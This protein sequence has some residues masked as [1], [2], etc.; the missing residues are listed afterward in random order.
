MKAM[1]Y[2]NRRWLGVT[3]MAAALLVL[4]P[5]AEAAID[6][7]TGT[8]FEFTAKEGYITTPD[9]GSIYC[10]GYSA[11]GT[12]SAH[13]DGRMQYPGPTLIL[14]EGQTY[15][16]TLSN[17]LP[18]PVSLIFPGLTVT[19]ASGDVDGDIT[20]E[21]NAY[22]AGTEIAGTA[23]YT[24][25]ADAPGT[26]LYHSG[27]NP[28]VQVEMGLLG[29]IVVRP[30][31]YDELDNRIAYNHADTAFGHEYLFLH[32]E[33]DPRV[34]QY[35]EFGMPTGMEWDNSDWWPVYW[36]FNGRAA[37]DDLL[38]S[39]VA[40]LPTQPYNL[41]PRAHPGDKVLMRVVGG[42]RESHPFHHHGDH[43]LVI[44]MDGQLLD[45]DAGTPEL[46]LA[47]QE[48]TMLVNPGQTMDAILDW[49]G[50]KMGWDIYGPP[51]YE[52]DQESGHICQDFFNNETGAIGSDG[53]ADTEE[54]LC[55]PTSPTPCYPYEWC[56][57][58]GRAIPV[59]LPE[60]QNLAFGA[61]WSG[62]PYL[63]SAGALPPGEGGLNPN[64]AYPFMWHS[65]KEKELTNNDIFPGGQLTMFFIEPHGVAID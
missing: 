2:R 48:F 40:W 57:D 43:A 51:Y 19:A 10:W 49:T 64:S 26:Y 15:T 60:T 45:G 28:K 32:T 25:T 11:Q 4:A 23:S 12:H 16:I 34:H 36:F 5:V 22:D 37:P 31:T 6:G 7:I 63:G 33:M 27:T 44:A 53:Y 55:D 62:S 29:V 17:E 59:L 54:Q 8:S 3:L 52:V 61:W 38:G 46:D 58:H 20:W 50:E 56:E 13:N 24:F 9:G 39:H 47:Y 18:V 35:Y 65:H 21:A 42:G 30:A 1:K 14:N 41:I